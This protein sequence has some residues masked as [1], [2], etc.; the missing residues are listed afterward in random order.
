[1]T[2]SAMREKAFQFL[3]GAE[4]QKE[5][6]SNQ[7]EIFLENNEVEDEEL[8]KYL[9]DIVNGI[10]QNKEKITKQIQENL[11]SDW[12]IERISKIS[13]ALL[14]LAIYEIQYQNLP[15]KAMINEVVELAKTYGE[16]TS[17]QFVN[18]VLASIV[19]KGEHE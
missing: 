12:Q 19:N 14:K 4:I 6:D 15:Y 16:D 3:Y 11:K 1:M 10:L 18:G 5:L 8:K 13:L 2:R 9:T 17:A 7:I